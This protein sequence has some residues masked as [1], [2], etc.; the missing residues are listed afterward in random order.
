M[1]RTIHL[2]ILVV[3]SCTVL[4]G[5]ATIVN[6]VKHAT[7][8]NTASADAED[9]SEEKTFDQTTEKPEPITE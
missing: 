5:C 2:I 1:I 3:L 4:S 9:T 6:E 7:T 8:V